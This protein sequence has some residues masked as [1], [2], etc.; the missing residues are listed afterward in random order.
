MTVSALSERIVKHPCRL[1]VL[2]ADSRPVIERIT[3][4]ALAGVPH[5]DEKRAFATALGDRRGTGVRAKGGIIAIGQWARGLGEHRG[6]HH[7][8]DTWQGPENLAVT[9]LTRL[10]IG[11]RGRRE[12]LQEA[13]DPP[14]RGRALLVDQP[15]LRQQRCD[16]QRDRVRDAGGDGEARLAQDGHDIVCGETTN[17]VRAQRWRNPSAGQRGQATG[18]GVSARIAQSHGS[19]AAGLSASQAASTR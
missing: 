19:S 12:L 13:I 3:K 9:M 8:S 1:V 6:G 16:A 15:P 18:S 14:V 2:N 17:A 5:R 10:A 11:A 7:S 4:A